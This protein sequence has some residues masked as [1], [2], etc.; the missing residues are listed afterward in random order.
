MVIAELTLAF[1]DN[2]A[3]NEKLDSFLSL[4]KFGKE[5]VAEIKLIRTVERLN[6]K[7]FVSSINI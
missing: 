6:V 1:V 3:P 4:P 7:N 2:G 5:V